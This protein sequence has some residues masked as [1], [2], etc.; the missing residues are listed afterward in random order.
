[1][2]YQMPDTSICPIPRGPHTPPA[3]EIR[4]G[5]HPSHSSERE[6]TLVR[7]HKLSS[8]HE[9]QDSPCGPRHTLL[10]PRHPF[11][12]GMG[13]CLWNLISLNQR[14]CVLTPPAVMSPRGSSSPFPTPTT[15]LLLHQGEWSRNGHQGGSERRRNHKR[16]NWRRRCPK[17]TGPHDSLVS[18]IISFV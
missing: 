12:R 7:M 4:T 13:L 15:Q 2:I 9:N 1:M 11:L 18:L 16:A 5:D 6:G 17:R 10:N 14:V 8:S 3:W